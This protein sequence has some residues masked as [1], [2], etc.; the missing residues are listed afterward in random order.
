[1]PSAIPVN[2]KISS[3]EF[4]AQCR[5]QMI[6][7]NKW[8]SYFSVVSL[9]DSDL[10]R[11][12][13]DPASAM[14]AKLA[15]ITPRLRLVFVPFLEKPAGGNGA[16][17]A[18]PIV[19]FQSP[20]RIARLLSGHF[21]I[22]G[23]TFIFLSVHDEDIVDAHHIFYQK[24][25]DLIIAR[26]GKADIEPFHDLVRAEIRG[27]IHGELDEGAWRLKTELLRKQKDAR[28]ETKLLAAY[29]RQA[30]KDT[31]VLYLHGL[32]CDIDV[33]GGPRYMAG[34]HIRK[35][36][37]LLKD[38]LPPPS[39]VALFPEDLPPAAVQ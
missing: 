1:M 31:L 33:A 37:L 11:L 10:Q 23:E 25:A 5:G 17:P 39:D 4:A 28:R 15:E 19:S 35:R 26:A 22:D 38:F 7:L 6:P 21:E 13:Y 32:C 14:P 30:L 20:N 29:R 18:G 12:V 2:S 36:L 16:G 27:N 34:S 9:D 8:L 24:L 3:A